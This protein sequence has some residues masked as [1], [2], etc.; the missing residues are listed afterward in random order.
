MFAVKVSGI[1]CM[2][3]FVSISLTMLWNLSVWLLGDR[4]GKSTL[5]G[6]TF[7]VKDAVGWNI[8]IDIPH[9]GVVRPGWQSEM[10]GS[11]RKLGVVWVR[12][13]RSEPYW[14]IRVCRISHQWRNVYSGVMWVKLGMAEPLPCSFS[15]SVNLNF[16][17]LFISSGSWVSINSFL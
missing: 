15:W 10:P 13:T 6:S 9:L 2:Q 16:Y 12:G 8:P 14:S 4:H 11:S 1:P 5:P 7:P 17:C 3:K